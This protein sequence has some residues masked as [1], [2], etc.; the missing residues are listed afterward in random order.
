MVG[1]NTVGRVVER[2]SGKKGEVGEE[3]EEEEEGS[4]EGVLCFCTQQLF[5]MNY[6]GANYP[7]ERGG[8]RKREGWTESW[9][10]SVSVY[11]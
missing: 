4:G 10:A 3:E 7:G 2:M 5:Q 1:V 9:P 8:E 6:V 11:M